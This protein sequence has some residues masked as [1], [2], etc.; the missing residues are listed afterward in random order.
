MTTFIQNKYTKYYYGIIENAR[1]RENTLYTEKHHIIP[2]SLGGD[3]NINNIV[4]LSA[5]E[6]FI[7]HRLLCKM[8]TDTEKAKMSYAAWQQGRSLHL[9]GMKISSRLYEQ[10]KINLSK[11]MTG[12]KRDQFSAEWR[13]N[14]SKGHMGDKN[15]MYGKP[16]SAETKQKMSENRKGKCG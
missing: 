10:L 16:R 5:R 6:H 14:I 11:S 9:K 7:C 8:T 15:S 1:S 3:N 13:E 12:R 4:K 2:K